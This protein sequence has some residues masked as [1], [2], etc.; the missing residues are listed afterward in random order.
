[1]SLHDA[2][3][4]SYKT[5]NEQKQILGQRGFTRDDSLSSHNQQVYYNKDKNKLL[6]TIAGTHNLNDWA[7]DVALALG[8]IKSTNRY[9]EAD[10]TLKRAQE[11]YQNAKTTIAGHSLG[12]T[13]AQGLHNRADKTV[14]LDAGYTIG[15]KTRGKHIRAAGDVVSLLAPN[16]KRTKTVKGGAW[17]DILGNHDVGKIKNKRIFV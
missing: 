16:D 10:N 15:Q 14:S 11:K 4:A 17:F 12:G 5:P 13:I 7:T 9:K 3:K 1:M 2:L 6:Y 8:K